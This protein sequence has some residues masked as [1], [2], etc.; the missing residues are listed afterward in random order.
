[1]I[2]PSKNQGLH[3]RKVWLGRVCGH[4]KD[5]GL[6]PLP[7]QRNIYTEV[8]LSQH[9]L[10]MLWI[11]QK[12]T[13]SYTSHFNIHSELKT[14]VAEETPHADSARFIGFGAE[15][16]HDDHQQQ[17]RGQTKES[18]S[19]QQSNHHKSRRGRWVLLDLQF[20]YWLVTYSG[21]QELHSWVSKL[22]LSSWILLLCH[23]VNS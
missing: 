1:M 17:Q 10:C 18:K 22:S 11:Y 15:G 20:V 4:I 19:H 5:F 8:A 23:F 13:R 14:K 16:D 6:Y 7:H 21:R 3:D 9:A 12:F 2:S